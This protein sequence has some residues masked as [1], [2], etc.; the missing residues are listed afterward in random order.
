MHEVDTEAPFTLINPVAVLFTATIF[1]EP[2]VAL[3]YDTICAT[4]GLV[5]TITTKKNVIESFRVCRFRF[6]KKCVFIFISF[7]FIK[8]NLPLKKIIPKYFMGKPPRF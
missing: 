5:F 7:L 1:G 2:F 3:V 6:L 8:I 4:D